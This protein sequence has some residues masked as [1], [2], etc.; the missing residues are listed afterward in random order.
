M[1]LDIR[2]LNGIAGAV[3]FAAAIGV[4]SAA[5]AEEQVEL[6][7]LLPITG[8][9]AFYGQSISASLGAVSQT[10]NNSGGVAGRPIHFTVLDDQASPQ[11]A[12]QLIAPLVAKGVPVIIDGGP[13][14]TC[15]AT[16]AL[17]KTD[18]V[19][20]CL[21]AAYNPSPGTYSF[22]T[23]FSL[24][25]GIA[26]QIRF[27]RVR[28]FKRIGFLTATDATGQ[29]SD[30]SVTRVLAYPENRDVVAV[31]REHFGMGDISV[32]AQLAHIK[33]GNPQALY[34]LASGT[35]LG[36][37][38]HDMRDM[39]MVIPTA[40]LASNNS[41]K[42][43]QTYGS[44]VPLDLELVTSRFGA[45]DVMRGGP[46]KEAIAKARAALKRNHV[47]TDGPAS[48]AWDPAMLIVAAYRKVGPSPTPVKLNSAIATM[49]NMA[50]IDG[51]YDFVSAPGRG[52]TSKDSVVLRWDGKRQD[53]VPISAAGGT[54]TL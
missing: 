26:A 4:A 45:Y 2:S 15:R 9:L 7:A 18:A 36:L 21:S 48:L 44:I 31:G 11:V 50:G 20:F 34:A 12:V 42:Q 30:A 43:M 6:Y 27:F 19:I 25:D 23:P 8:P 17:V 16:T 24:E 33:N 52:L 10:V 29:E 13:A 41:I 28:G 3:A 35:P 51:Y 47:N 40:T 1:K 46:V 54:S 14:A 39:G 53:F 49:R 22:S 38:L 5:R 32:S 37:V